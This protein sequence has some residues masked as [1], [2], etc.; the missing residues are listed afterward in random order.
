MGAQRQR[1]V[2]ALSSFFLPPWEGV[3]GVILLTL[4]IS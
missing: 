1:L 3:W 2:P 4:E